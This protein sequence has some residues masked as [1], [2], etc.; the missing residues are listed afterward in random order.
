[1]KKIT[2]NLPSAC[3]TAWWKET[4][5]RQSLF[6]QPSALRGL[7]ETCRICMSRSCLIL[8]IWMRSIAS[9]LWVYS[10][11][12]QSFF[13]LFVQTLLNSAF[14]LLCHSP[15]LFT[16]YVPYITFICDRPALR[17]CQASSSLDF[18]TCD[19]R[20]KLVRFFKILLEWI[21]LCLER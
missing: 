4:L 1:M 16:S 17:S 11:T 18:E 8:W 9:K 12:S 21:E 20:T 7:F 14:F 15:T 5:V 6:R 10:L 13:F 2:S 3:G 19:L